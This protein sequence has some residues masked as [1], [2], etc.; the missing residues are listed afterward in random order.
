MGWR[1][2]N[3]H[4]SQGRILLIKSQKEETIRKFTSKINN[5]HKCKDLVLPFLFVSELC[6]YTTLERFN[7]YKSYAVWVKMAVSFLAMFCH[8][9]K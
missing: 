6:L 5:V 3:Q 7:N 2:L 1:F 8:L 9:T 4:L